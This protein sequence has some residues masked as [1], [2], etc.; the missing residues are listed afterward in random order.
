MLVL[1]VAYIFEIKLPY[2]FHGKKG[3]ALLLIQY[4][5]AVWI[6]ESRDETSG[7][8]ALSIT[9]CWKT[10]VQEMGVSFYM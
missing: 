3:C 8:I 2:Q 10:R 7:H 4:L 1:G 5:I 9:F 6:R